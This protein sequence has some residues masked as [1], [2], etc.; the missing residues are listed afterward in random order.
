MKTTRL[1]V[2]SCLLCV[3]LLAGCGSSAVGNPPVDASPAP[4]AAPSAAP[5]VAPT[6]APSAVPS[7]AL[8]DELLKPDAPPSASPQ[9]DALA[10]A[11]SFVDHDLSELVAALGEPVSAV[12][13][14]SC[15]GSGQD[16]ELKYDGFTVI[17]YR[18]GSTE[19]VTYV[20]AAS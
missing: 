7:A 15:L 8:P 14:P 1:S 19:T 4:S 12:Y 11:K 5:S 9:E 17:T 18:E 20:D 2:L 16:G 3:L 10:L 6:A 13:V